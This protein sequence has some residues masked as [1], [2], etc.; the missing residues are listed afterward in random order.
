[1]TKMILISGCLIMIN[2][3]A[4]RAGAQDQINGK[5]KLTGFNFSTKQKF[6]IEKMTVDLTITDNKIGGHSGCN[7]FGGNITITRKGKMKVGPL[8]STERFCDEVS[9][10]FESLFT[11]T[12]QN[13]SKISLKNGILT[14]TETKKKTFLRFERLKELGK[15]P[16][17]EKDQG[18][19]FVSKPLRDLV[20]K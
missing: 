20:K 12:L 13:A 10:Q 8:T 16:I 19:V 7:I 18:S 15:H 5:W 11:D 9:G 14:I 3:F 2:A 17:T 6:S 1:M 4:S